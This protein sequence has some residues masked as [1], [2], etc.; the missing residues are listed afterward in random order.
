MPFG[1]RIEAIDEKPHLELIKGPPS[2]ALPVVGGWSVATSSG[3]FHK[4]WF[5]WGAT[6]ADCKGEWKGG[7]H[8]V[9]TVSCS[10]ADLVA[11]NA[12]NVFEAREIRIRMLS[13]HNGIDNQPHI[14]PTEMVFDGMQLN[15]RPISIVHDNDFSS[16][17]TLAQFEQEYQKNESFFKKYQAC[18]RHPH[19]APKFGAPL[20]RTPGGFVA[21]S[22]VRGLNW[23]GQSIQGNVL[24]LKG[25]GSIYFGEVLLNDNNRRITMVRL[26]MGCA[27]QAT[28][29]AGEADPNGTWG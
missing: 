5:E 1:G 9:T 4:E 12:P 6:V 21:A 10:I 15:G 7:E 8:Y 11:R 26:E 22:F 17:P 23:S 3:S 24:S 16:F 19:G 13:D 28:A 20:P 27:G 25:F 2:A 29:A 18:L 14:V